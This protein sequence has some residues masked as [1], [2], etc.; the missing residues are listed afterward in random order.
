F[1]SDGDG[2]LTLSA[3]Y[4][5]VTPSPSLL[6]S[7]FQTGKYVGPRNAANGKASITINGPGVVNGGST[8]WSSASNSDA[9]PCTFPVSA[10]WYVGPMENNPMAA[11]LKKVGITTTAWTF[12]V[13]GPGL[14]SS[15]GVGLSFAWGSGAIIGVNQSGNSIT[16]ASF[17]NN[18]F[19]KDS[20]VD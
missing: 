4:P 20:P 14:P 13:A 17:T 8:T 6:S 7:S 19:D 1:D 11:R 15:C 10:T 5:I 16:F 18:S 2:N 3:G 9:D 12:G